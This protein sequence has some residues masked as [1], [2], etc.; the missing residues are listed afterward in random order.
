M[1]EPYSFQ[2]DIWSVGCICS[3][4]VTGKRPYS[5]LVGVAA[6]FRMCED[7]TPPLP[8]SGI[9]DMCRDFILQCW[10]KDWR[11]VFNK[12]LSD[13]LIAQ[14]PSAKELLSHA[15]LESA[16]DAGPRWAAVDN[17]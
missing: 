14:R 15:F 13:Y 4:L 6:M 3:E 8:T 11:K 7:A 17:W 1:A 2:A 16:K 9:S 12:A 5:G 10:Q